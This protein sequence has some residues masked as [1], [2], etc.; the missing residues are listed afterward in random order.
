[1]KKNINRI[2]MQELLTRAMR[3]A[4]ADVRGGY[5]CVSISRG[6]RKMGNIKSISLLPLVSCPRRCRGTCGST[7]KT[8]GPC[9]AEKLCRIY[10]DTCKAWAHNTALAILRPDVF[11]TAV[12]I[13]EE[14]AQTARGPA[15][16]VGQRS[17]AKRLLS[18]SINSPAGA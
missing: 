7:S 15:R 8:Q 9:Y 6:N 3:E 13:A 5:T 10:P 17:P 4:L 14:T 18:I 1:M 12:E 16:V 11:W 2:N